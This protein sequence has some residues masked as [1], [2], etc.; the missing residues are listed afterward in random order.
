MSK[1]DLKTLGW[2]KKM[3]IDNPKKSFK[4]WSSFLVMSTP[5]EK[6]A[7]MNAGN[8]T[9]TIDIIKIDG[10]SISRSKKI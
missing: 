7:K 8:K 1:R 2:N 3:I 9:N 5:T 10:M 6:I 4:E